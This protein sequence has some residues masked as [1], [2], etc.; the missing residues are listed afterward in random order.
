MR[1]L[2]SGGGTGGHIYPALSII[3]SLIK[4]DKDAKILYAGTPMGLEK[5]LVKKEG[6]DY[7]PIR[8][9]GMPRNISL[10]SLKS[11]TELTKGLF[12]ARK[13]VKNFRPD[14]AIGTGGYVSFPT[15][16]ICQQKKIKTVI[17]EQNA[18]A[19]KANK[20]LGKKASKIAI[21][22]E[23]AR[24]FFPADKCFVSGN[25][26]REE[27]YSA[28][29]KESRKKLNIEDNKKVVVTFGGSG[30]QRTIN[31]AVLKMLERKQNF[32]LLH[33]TGK[34][35]YEKFL[36]D[37]KNQN[38]CKENDFEII[39]YAYNIVDLLSACDLAIL[40]SSAISLAEIAALSKPSIL[41]PKAYT[42]ENHQEYNAMAFK[43]KGASEVIL[44]KDL[45]DE[46]LE[47]IIYKILN[48]DE[49]SK[50]MS[51]NAKKMSF[52]NSS[53]MIAKEIIEL[54]R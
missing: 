17:Q 52:P 33:I 37:L 32:K 47:E 49:V 29:K 51:E 26:I 16:F 22:F 28:N 2:V 53:E 27:F 54:I 18:F 24:K 19:G 14:V 5:E 34:D 1:Y 6:Y 48:D 43:E 46:K 30:G 40:S 20:F 12:D 15:L 42:A 25:P 36:E 38:T 21:A 45:N 23:E 13:A 10:E 44:E 31:A 41:I 4:L 39:S 35:H 50:I 8:I 9:Q 7:V 11:A 3:D